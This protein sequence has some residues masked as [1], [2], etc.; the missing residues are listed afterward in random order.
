MVPE[1]KLGSILEINI[2]QGNEQKNQPPGR[3]AGRTYSYG[4]LGRAHLNRMVTP[5]AEP[6]PPNITG[7]AFNA[8]IRLVI[9]QL[10]V[11]I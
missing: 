10:N 9:P 8:N 5:L 4:F 2:E 7:S 3:H 1:K 11:F 6:D